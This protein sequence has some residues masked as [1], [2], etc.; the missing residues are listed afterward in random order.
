MLYLDKDSRARLF[1]F[2]PNRP[3][4]SIT[5]NML[6]AMKAKTPGTPKRSRKNAIANEL[7][8]TENRLQE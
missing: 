4:E 8:I 3:I 1:V 5:I 7:N 6:P 2:G